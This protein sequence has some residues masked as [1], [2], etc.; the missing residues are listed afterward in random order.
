MINELLLM[1]ITII[2]TL[3]I[4]LLARAESP[5]LF[6]TIA[7]NLILVTIFGGQMITVF[8]LTTNVGNV[9]YAHVFLATYFLLERSNKKNIYQTIWFGA[10]SVFVFLVLSELTRWFTS[11]NP[12]SAIDA[13]L[14]VIF[15]VSPR[16]ALGSII[17]YVFAQYIN[18]KI[19][20]FLQQK[21]THI[22]IGFR[23]NISNVIA[24][25]ADCCIFFSIAFIDLSGTALI[26]AIFA[27]WIIKSLVVCIATPFLYVDRCLLDKKRS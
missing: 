20:T 25:F 4:F 18:I 19:Y 10:V 14:H 21:W 1:V 2:D 17:A 24:Q 27:G 3:L 22:H 7:L 5:R 12:G 11:A 16:I 8:G 23:S 15:T 6:G 9:F 26:Q 13:A